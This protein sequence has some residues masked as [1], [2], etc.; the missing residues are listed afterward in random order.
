M[1]HVLET[2]DLH[3]GLWWGDLRE[4]G[5]LK[6]IGLN[7]KILLNWVLTKWNGEAGTGLIWLSIG[8]L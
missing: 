4:R 5:H 7:E 6:D 2:G 3:T 1:W 8:I